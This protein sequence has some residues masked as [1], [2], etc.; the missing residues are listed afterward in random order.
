MELSYF[1]A[2]LFGL[3]MMIFA[4]ITL[5]RPA[6]VI[7]AI[8]DLKP[9]SFTMLM[10]GF[11]GIIGGLAIILSHNIWVTDW[12]VVITLFGWTALIKGVVYIA[13]PDCIIMSAGNLLDGSKS[14]ATILAI[15]FL[16]GLYLA[17]NGFGWSV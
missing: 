8:R 13:F 16:F 17:Y 7:G 14:R 5:T 15:A 12:R 4:A 1:L 10:A 6:I 9:Y 11:V 2:Q 3:T